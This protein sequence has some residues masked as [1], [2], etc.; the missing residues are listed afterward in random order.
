[1]QNKILVKINKIQYSKAKIIFQLM[2]H[3]KNIEPNKING[4]ERI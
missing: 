3:E 4:M 1:M 2:L